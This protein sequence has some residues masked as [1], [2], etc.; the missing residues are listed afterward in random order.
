MLVMALAQPGELIW[1]AGITAIVTTEK[2]RQQP[3]GA[4]RYAAGA[5]AL[6]A[7]IT[8]AYAIGH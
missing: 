5:L 3:R 2:L 8:A 4:T 7:L 1:M 6:A